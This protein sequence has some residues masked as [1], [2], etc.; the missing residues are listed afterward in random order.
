MAS[1]QGLASNLTH[2]DYKA[3]E[4]V[5]KGQMVHFWEGPR[6]ADKKF[7]RARGPQIWNPEVFDQTRCSR[8]LRVV[9]ALNSPTK[10]K[11]MK[12]AFSLNHLLVGTLRPPEIGVYPGVVAIANHSAIVNAL[13]IVNLLPVV[14]LVQRAPLGRGS[15]RK[16][17]FLRRIL[18][19]V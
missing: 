7:A 6:S 1:S 8:I 13:R 4:K 15:L 19:S 17:S 5:P 2:K 18:V 14:F 12:E 11:Q 10:M 9:F 16:G 3:G